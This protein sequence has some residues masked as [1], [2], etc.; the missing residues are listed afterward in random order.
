MS[1]SNNDIQAAHISFLVFSKQSK[2]KS[3]TLIFLRLIGY[4]C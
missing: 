3:L 1:C 4:I 2:S